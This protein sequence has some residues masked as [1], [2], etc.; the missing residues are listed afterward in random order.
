MI[1][2]I[3]K[4]ILRLAGVEVRRTKS[5]RQ[6]ETETERK[7]RQCERATLWG[8]LALAARNGLT[9]ATVIDC[10][11]AFGTS[12]LYA[13]FPDAHHVLIEPLK[14]YQPALERVARSLKSGSLVMAAA[15]AREGTLTIHVHPDLVGSS[16]YLE[17]EDSDVNGVPRE[18]SAV[19]LDSV[20]RQLGARG[21]YLIKLDVQGSELDVLNGAT[22]VLTDTDLV[23]METSLFEFYKGAPQ[24]G[25]VITFMGK[26]NFVPYD[27]VG[28]QYRLLDGAMSQ[29]DVVFVKQSCILR[30][31]HFYA[32]RE[33]RFAQNQKI[34]ESHGH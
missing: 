10:G 14:E 23:V 4:Q 3:V 22:H 18:V 34:K 12:E 8:A 33:Q 24:V 5:S 15:A 21:P 28:A 27:L 19:T 17:E 31:H 1:K 9:P 25:D 29:V 7:C 6:R 30:K 2:S 26:Q 13:N 20:C 16:S 11:A 32:T